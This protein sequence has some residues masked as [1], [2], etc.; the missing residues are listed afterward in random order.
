MEIFFI[1]GFVGGVLRGAVGLIK[2]SMSYKDVTIRPWYFAGMVV[3]SGII[4]ATAAW[5]V[6]DLGIEFLGVES[7]SPAL[8]V[9]IGYA[10]GDFLEN[11]FKII[12]KKTS[13][14]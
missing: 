14:F 2:Y 12:T 6:H 3:I 13:L 11:A 8:A 4:G 7:L 9:V 5:I 1:A 10:G